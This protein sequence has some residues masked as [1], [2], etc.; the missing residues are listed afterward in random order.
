MNSTHRDKTIR[1]L[2]SK[3]GLRGKIDAKCCECI[4]DPYQEGTWRLQVEKC[5]SPACPLFSVR[6][7]TMKGNKVGKENAKK[8]NIPK[9][10]YN[11]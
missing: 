4:Y 1:K 9:E 8:V 3:P 7:L 11:E 2:A 10:H 6:P 5:T